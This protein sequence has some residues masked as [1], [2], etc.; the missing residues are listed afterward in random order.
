ML[1]TIQT[2]PTHSPDS[3]E[4][5]TPTHCLKKHHNVFIELKTCLQ[6]PSRP[7]KTIFSIQRFL[8]IFLGATHCQYTSNDN[9]LD[10]LKPTSSFWEIS[11]THSATMQSISGKP[12]SFTCLS[13]L[14][15][16]PQDAK[17]TILCNHKP[18]EKFL[19]GKIKNNKVSNWST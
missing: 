1:T 13:T 7:E 2:L 10:D 5:T 4:R 19:K 6:K 12:L 17:W 9:F 14:S 15:Y 8:Q 3:W 16:Y 11:Q 18:L